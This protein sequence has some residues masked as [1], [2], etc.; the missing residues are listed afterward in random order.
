VGDLISSMVVGALWTAWGTEVA[1]GYSAIL[2][3]AGSLLATRVGRPDPS[4]R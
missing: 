1:F 2:F 4:T 3:I